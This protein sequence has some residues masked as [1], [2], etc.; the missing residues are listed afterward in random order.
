[1]SCSQAVATYERSGRI[2]VTTR[3]GTTLPI[4]DGVPVSKKSTL[5]CPQ[6][7]IQVQATDNKRCVVAYKCGPRSHGGR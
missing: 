4:Y 1:M 2:T 6:V 3:S 5:R 7:A